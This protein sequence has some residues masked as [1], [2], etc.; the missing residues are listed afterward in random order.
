VGEKGKPAQ[1]FR[2]R[3]VKPLEKVE[4]YV[5]VD[6]HFAGKIDMGEGKTHQVYENSWAWYKNPLLGFHTVSVFIT[7]IK[8]KIEE[9]ERLLEYRPICG[10]INSPC[11]TDVPHVEF[12]L[13][14]ASG[15]E[16]EQME[17]QCQRLG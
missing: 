2:N 8:T 11:P 15:G 10:S 5:V 1:M 9:G 13:E 17:A 6:G 3:F 12:L 14:K 16:I 7:R 4:V